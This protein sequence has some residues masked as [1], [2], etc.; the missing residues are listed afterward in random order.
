MPEAQLRLS[1]ERIID[2]AQKLADTNGAPALTM[3]SIAKSLGVEA[4]SLYHHFA[5]KDEILDA[6]VDSVFS[7]ITLPQKG[8]PWAEEM[9]VRAQSVR[10]VLLRHH[11]AVG[12][13][14][15]RRNPGP[16]TLRHHDHVIGCLRQ[17]NFS[18]EQAAHT[19]ATLDSYIYG[20]VLQEISL[21]FNTAD[22]GADMF[23][24]I[25]SN[26]ADDYP[27]LTEM[28]TEYTARLEY[29][30]ADEF[31]WGLSLILDAIARRHT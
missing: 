6:L 24:E 29:D 9:R 8:A 23:A 30:F 10:E 12:L 18:I 26:T 2:A 14:D 25:L 13:L 15:S 28:A 22:H 21:P 1:R 17:E 3:R 19:F 5:N 4:M 27:H 7:E 16:A 31:E 20:F 11:W